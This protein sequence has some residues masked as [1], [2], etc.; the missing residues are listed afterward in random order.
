MEASS[1]VVCPLKV[2]QQTVLNC[3][4]VHENTTKRQ[5]SVICFVV[6]TEY[7]GSSRGVMQPHHILTQLEIY[8]G[9]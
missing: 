2:C 3:E 1:L 7:F 8:F 5:I 9:T 4:K 6:M